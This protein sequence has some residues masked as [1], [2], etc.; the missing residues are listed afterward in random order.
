LI[1]ILF[2]PVGK[3][4]IVPLFATLSPE[5][6]TTLRER[7]LARFNLEEARLLVADLGENFDDL[8]GETISGKIQA[9][10]EH[11]NR[12]DR[13]PDLIA[14]LQELRPVEEWANVL[15]A[16]PNA[17]S[18]YKGLLYFDEADAPLFFGREQVTAELI[19]HLRQ[20]RFL[21]VVGASG[22]G[23]SSV[24]RAGV[25]PTIRRGE[26]AGE[27][28]SSAAWPVHL[29]TP[30]D[31]P[32]KALAATLTRDSES[33]TATKTLLADLQ[34]D[35]DSLDLFLYRQM[36]ASNGRCLLIVDQ[37]EEL[38]TQ[39]RD[40]AA[41]EM[42]VG[43][44]V[45]AV[46][47][48]QQARLSLIL[49]LRADFYAQAVQLEALRPLLETRQKIIGAMT[50]DELRQAIEGPATK[51]HWALQPG[52]VETMLQDAGREPGALP[53]LSHALQETWA[54]REG[55]TLTLAG[56][57]AAGGV[58]RAIAQTADAV[59]AS[60]TPEQQTIARNIFLRLTELGEGTEDTRRRV[61]LAE[62]L[63]EGEG[64]TAVR[65]LLDLL[66]RKRLV[67]LNRETAHTH[68]EVAHEALIREWPA[69]RD[70]LD[71]N[72][73]GLRLHRQLTEAAG[74]WGAHGEDESYLYRGG[75]LAQ[76]REWA[77]QAE[78]QLNVLEQQFL[79][80]S[81]TAEEQETVEREAQARR[82]L[83]TVQKLAESQKRELKITAERVQAER[84]VSTRTRVF[85]L[86]MTM[87]AAIL[88]I[89]PIRT[90]WLRQQAKGPG[91][92]L[93]LIGPV[94]TRLG[95]DELHKNYD[96]ALPE[97]DYHVDAF[98]IERFE[99]TNKRYLLCVAAGKCS[100]PL[101]EAHYY[102]DQAR[103]N[104]PVARVTAIQAH[105]FCYWIGR[106]LPTELEWE[107]AARTADAT[108]WPWGDDMPDSRDIAN[109]T[110]NDA[111][112][113][114][115]YEDLLH[116]VGQSHGTPPDWTIYDLAGNV[117]EW[118]SQI[119][120][121]SKEF[122][123][124]HTWDGNIKNLPKRL[125]IKGGGVGFTAATIESMAFHHSPSP[126]GVSSD[127]L[128]GFRCAVDIP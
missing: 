98:A 54:R 99:V 28:G 56:Y 36:G 84:R 42:F 73:D 100:Y 81:Q 97:D 64:E 117:W 65:D 108:T 8:R 53:L 5:Q 17:T 72:R 87:V 60:L 26:I 106:R 30:G 62:L 85:F 71:E 70:W 47:S 78:P 29:I 7:I 109:F 122:D 120:T 22:S 69:L 40:A 43:N 124:K 105:E 89:D 68:A 3:E 25:I 92:L 93:V 16:E 57:Q 35:S 55:R 24:V 34:A 110:Y 31:E 125:V 33:V 94:M 128:I 127:F 39:C 74:A 48:G 107:V 58:R 10:L 111:D 86:L 37:F 50:P 96:N 44:L 20:H 52:L 80:A 6:L 27:Q 11:L 9:L 114:S 18:P 77:A 61:A 82:E 46:I 101:S 119:W 75:R 123:P 2:P 66:A 121:D 4:L 14:R 79:V 118:T 90:E 12:R 112:G 21:A 102:Q 49:T 15:P 13:L 51:E 76:A 88:S 59:Y 91:D 63:P 83:E 113:N 115:G 38:F 95:D 32:L 116:E 1:S 126:F 19:A 41:R 67:T 45:T 23:K 103:S 104:Y